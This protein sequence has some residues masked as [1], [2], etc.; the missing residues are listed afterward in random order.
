MKSI[1]QRSNSIPSRCRLLRS[2]TSLTAMVFSI[3]AILFLSGNAFSSEGRAKPNVIVIL[4]DD[5]GYNDL[6][7]QGC[8]D[9]PTPNIDSLAKNGVRCTSGYVTCCVCSPSRAGLI[10]GRYQQ[11]FGHENNPFGLG[12]GLPV[13]EV[14]IAD[15]LKKE[16]YVT[17]VIGKWHLGDLTHFRPLKRGFDE[18]FGFLGG[19]HD[20]LDSFSEIHNPIVRNNKIVEEKEYL[21]DALGREA[22]SFIDRHQKEPFFLYL[23][24][25]AVHTPMH[26]TEK[27]LKRFPD[28]KNKNRRACAA[29]LSAM[30]DNVGRVLKKLRDTGLE[31]DTLIFYFSDNGGT[32]PS[33]SDNTPLKDF[34]ASLYEGGIRVPFLVQ[35]KG[36][37]PEGK[38]YDYP[39]S[40]LDVLPTALALA[41]AKVPDKKEYDGVNL[42]PYLTGK[43]KQPPHEILFWRHH[44]DAAVRMGKWKLLRQ[45][46]DPLE[47]FDLS[48]DIGEK[49]NLAKENP[50]VVAKMNAALKKWE[51]ELAK[52]L[53]GYGKLKRKRPK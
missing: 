41:G 7:C 22:V 48:K 28:I 51:S 26:A 42:I 33:S 46:E 36:Q 39:V 3:G 8:K 35:W 18:F 17:G 4:A 44:T 24:F 10:T 47:L 43:N 31:K 34:K 37:L 38:T 14:T 50:E 6:G 19:A 9:I 40:S 21:T 29:M 53:W 11:R 15:R 16:G 52:P 45:E 25:N 20:Y 13:K 27:Y 12:L 49:T 23:P 30:D 1:H 2:V 5:Q 32:P